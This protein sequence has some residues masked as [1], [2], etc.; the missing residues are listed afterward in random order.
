MTELGVGI[1][2]TLEVFGYLE[3]SFNGVANSWSATIVHKLSD[4]RTFMSTNMLGIS[5]KGVGYG[6][7]VGSIPT[8]KTLILSW[9]LS[10]FGE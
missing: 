1:L 4:K 2:S 9:I 8:N 10:I 5:S 6:C 7:V 3:A